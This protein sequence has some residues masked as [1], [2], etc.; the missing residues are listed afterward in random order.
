MN[1]PTTAPAPITEYLQG[2][3]GSIPAEGILQD[4]AAV[5]KPTD[6]EHIVQKFGPKLLIEETDKVAQG[7]FEY[8]RCCGNRKALL[9]G[10]NYIGTDN[11]LRGCINDA[12]NMQKFIIDRFGFSNDNIV[13]LTDDTKD[14]GL[15]PT[16]A[17]IVKYMQWLV[18]D[19]KKD[20]ALFFHYSGHGTQVRDRVLD[21]PDKKDEAICPLDFPEVGMFIDDDSTHEQ[22][23]KPLPAGC[24]LTAVF[25]SC[26]S[27]SVMDIPYVY[28]PDKKDPIKEPKI[29]HVQHGVLHS[30]LQ[31]LGQLVQGL[32]KTEH[33]IFD[34]AR[35]MQI[36]SHAGAS[37]ADVVCWSGCL[38]TQTS[39]D[40]FENGQN[41]GALSWAFITSLTKDPTQTYME[42]LVSIRALLKQKY[43][44][45]VQLSSCHPI[46]TNLE[47][48]A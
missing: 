20:D 33:K 16:K 22:L 18:K 11:E 43:T 3:A 15:K 4:F 45:I 8:S 14:P 41:V 2:N 42:L 23:V 28:Q 48:V 35:S 5:L 24:R 19:A 12:R 17:N 7:F 30:L 34:P 29:L 32:D 44:Q 25:D 46:D 13:L 21:E 31:P 6:G 27:G 36:M 26:N 39:A 9:V 38:D 40:T 47:F 10:I 1:A 37:P